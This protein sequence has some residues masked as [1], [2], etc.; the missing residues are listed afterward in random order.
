[1]LLNIAFALQKNVS[2]AMIDDIEIIQIFFNTLAA[3]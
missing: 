1:M 2:A 3:N